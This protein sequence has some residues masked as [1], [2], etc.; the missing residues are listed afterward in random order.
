MSQL[1]TLD[2]PN[3]GIYLKGASTAIWLGSLN[4]CFNEN[5]MS[6]AI[7][8]IYASLEEV[9]QINEYIYYVPSHVGLSAIYNQE[10][11][12]WNLPGSSCSSLQK[13]KGGKTRFE[14]K[15]LTNHKIKYMGF[16][17]NNMLV[18][19][20]TIQETM[21]IFKT[22]D[23]NNSQEAFRQRCIL[24]PFNLCT[25]SSLQLTVCTDSQPPIQYK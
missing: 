6:D 8:I 17:H 3:T 23:A 9:H 18:G 10:V 13:T 1:Y 14:S 5:R 4:V 22:A 24:H 7:E 20:I 25:C 2:I 12:C 15:C 11:S 19:T 16:V 21:E